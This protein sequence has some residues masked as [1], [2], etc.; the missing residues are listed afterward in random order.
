[1][2]A[3]IAAG[4]RGLQDVTGHELVPLRIVPVPEKQDQIEPRQEGPAQA[5]LHL[6]AVDE[7]AAHGI[8]GRDHGAPRHEGADQAGLGDR[9]GLLFHGLVD[10][11]H[12]VGAHGRQLVDAADTAVG[13]DQGPG[14]QVP[15]VCVLI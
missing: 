5:H 11:G 6:L 10:R 14:L 7:P 9:Y 4:R 12:V 2:T 3:V 13:R 8:D 15:A 1:M